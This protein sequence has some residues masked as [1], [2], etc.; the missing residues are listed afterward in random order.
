MTKPESIRAA[1]A[2]DQR[3]RTVDWRPDA[4]KGGVAEQYRILARIEPDFRE[5]QRLAAGLRR[6]GWLGPREF[7]SAIAVN[8]ANHVYNIALVWYGAVHRGMVSESEE[9]RDLLEF[10]GGTPNVVAPVA[11]MR[12][13]E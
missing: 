6:R 9:V 1:D 4:E 8:Y 13:F 11:T 2:L 3:L 10:L 5:T 12:A 7:G